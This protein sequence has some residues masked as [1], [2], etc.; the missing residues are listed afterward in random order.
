MTIRGFAYLTKQFLLFQAFPNA[1]RHL[2]A[3]FAI[4]KQILSDIGHRT[5]PNNG[6]ISV[7]PA[8]GSDWLVAAQ[9]TDSVG[10]RFFGASDSEA[11]ASSFLCLTTLF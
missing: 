2:F 7:R 10:C 6:E 4:L 11:R 3:H 9:T 1:M 5:H 8:G